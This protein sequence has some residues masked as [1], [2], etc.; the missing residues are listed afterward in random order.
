MIRQDKI[1][2]E[3]VLESKS[4]QY[5]ISRALI[6]SRAEYIID[7]IMINLGFIEILFIYLIATISRKYQLTIFIFLLEY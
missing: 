6:I 4:T 2:R 1:S 3:P 5:K 7:K